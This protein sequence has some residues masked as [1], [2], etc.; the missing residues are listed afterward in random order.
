VSGICAA[1]AFLFAY[2]VFTHPGEV[3]YH[4]PATVGSSR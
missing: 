1:L 2:A 3:H 4:Y